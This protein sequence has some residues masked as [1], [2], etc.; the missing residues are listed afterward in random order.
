MVKK[1]A[2]LLTAI[3]IV[4]LWS[5]ATYQ[6]SPPSIY[7]EELPSSWISQLSLDERIMTEEAWEYLRQG[8]TAKAEK[9]ISKMG[10][11]SPFYYAGLGYAAFISRDLATAENMFRTASENYPAMALGFIGLAQVY[12]D[13]GLQEKAFSA[14]RL[15]LRSQP[16]HPWAKPRFENI[17]NQMIETILDEAETQKA[18]GNIQASREAF[19]KVLYYDPKSVEAH[20]A[21]A[22]IF[23]DE[24]NY[25]T[26][27]F[28][29]KAAAVQQPDNLNIIKMYADTLFKSEKYRDSMEAYENI[30]E[31]EPENKDAQERL[32]TIKNRLGIYELP[33]QYEAINQSEAVSKEEMA[34]LLSVK[35]KG[36]IDETATTPPIII[37]ISTSWA[38]E[39]ILQV[40]SLGLMDVNPNHTFQPKRAVTRA[41]MAEI[42]FRLTEGLKEKGITFIQQIP[43][44]Q[45]EI[46]DVS[47]DNF[48]YQP[49]LTMVSY[50]I[51][52]LASDKTFNPD[53]SISGSEAIKYLE[54]ILALIR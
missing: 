38:S 23:I 22:E 25:E 16:D 26:A 43:K 9:L 46:T 28:H 39:Y 51:I 13:Q 48:F 4:F 27:L 36:L 21:L 1:Y 40:T 12:I 29:L 50:D 34:S 10:S 19:L 5:C 6:P 3:G 15:A 41:E 18:S 11:Q 24:E 44:S 20:L 42:L 37:D 2:I 47:P 53:M 17:K 8:Y 45:I 49:I 35:F 33:R 14:L 32:Q 30:K 7:I 52:P 54:I 31:V